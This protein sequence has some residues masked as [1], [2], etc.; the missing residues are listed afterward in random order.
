MTPE[1]DISVSVTPQYLPEQ[2]D[3]AKSLY[4]FAYHITI[5][6]RGTK[7]AQLISRHWIITDSNG[8]VKEV[9]GLGVVGEQPH[10]ESGAEYHYSSGVVLGTEVGAMEGSYQMQTADGGMF[11]VAIPAFR[12]SLP[13]ILH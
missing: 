13:G 3:P 10:L 12:L 2:S 6:N 1:Y 7:S 8:R 4:T 11:D 9:Q 5:E